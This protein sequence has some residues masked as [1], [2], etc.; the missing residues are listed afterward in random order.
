M[1]GRLILLLSGLMLV[2]WLSGCGSNSTSEGDPITDAYS[3]DCISCHQTMSWSEGLVNDYQNSPHNAEG[4]SHNNRIC[5]KC[6]TAEGAR[7][8][9]NVD[10]VAG[11]ETLVD[12]VT[13]PSQGVICQACHD[14]SHTLGKFLEEAVVVDNVTVESA[15][16][17]TCTNCHQDHN[18]RL[19]DEVQQLAGSTSS[20]GASGD[21]IYHAGRF[22]RVISS[23]H[24]D[25]PATSDVI[26]G[27]TM[28]PANERACRDCHNVH[29]ADVTIN[30]QWA[31]SGHGGKVLAIK[32][33]L[34]ADDHSLQ[35]AA[36]YRAAGS[37]AADSPA[38]IY[39]DW[40][41][42]DRQGCQECHTATGARNFLSDPVN[43]D[44]ADNNFVHLE[45]WSVDNEGNVASSGQNELLYCWGCHLDS[46]SG[47]LNNPGALSLSYSVGGQLPVL[48][49]LGRSNICINCHAGRGNAESYELSGDPSADL[50]SFRP[51]FGP[52]TK[53]VTATHYF[54]AAATLF[55]E[56]TR[57]GYEFSGQSYE[58]VAFFR[59]DQIGLDGAAEGEQLGPCVGC[60][61]QSEQSHSFGVVNRDAGMIGQLTS[62]ACLGCHTGGHGPALVV[63][64][65]T[66]EFGLQ[67]A[68]AAAEFLNE[69]AEGY[70]QAL[71][72][73]AEELASRGV[74]YTGNYPYFT[75]SSWVNE[76]VFGAAHNY[77]YLHHEPGGYAHNRFYA[78]RLLF[79]SIDW[80]D[81]D[82]LDGTINI[83][84]S[85]YP[86][87]AHWL[88]TTRP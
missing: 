3:T 15:E 76:G 4:D 44:P 41:G 86:H 66:T 51:G 36:D 72:V 25:N 79:D 22:E 57:V 71:E 70:H 8:Y 61:M 74:T 26:E 46:A 69:E 27:Y 52:G 28:N 82:H 65:T 24:Y 5:A 77:N 43:Y 2:V 23:S 32:E 75:A 63:E 88:G 42:G 67:T 50:Q 73:L 37:T 48:N 54:A 40:D 9:V 16:Y 53:N 11:L 18:A 38:W 83:D 59:H 17:A 21:L 56:F 80:V 64:D 31:R 60:H 34:G 30:Q 7:L 20:D 10:T 39:Y 47:E 14:P 55:Q 33:A 49:D 12:A 58:N 35:G 13:S 29:S 19:G 62:R 68:A 85:V 81:N 84:E 87:A 78:K 45:G 1:R 6:H